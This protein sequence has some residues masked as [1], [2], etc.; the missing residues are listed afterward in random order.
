MAT[1][2]IGDV[3]GCYDSLRKLLDKLHFD[4]VSDV[5]WLTGDLVNRGPA[6]A[7]V[8]RFLKNMPRTQ[9]VLGNHDL[10]LLAVAQGH[11][12]R[13][14][15]DTFDDVLRAD[16]R[17]PLLDWLRYRPLAHFDEDRGILMVHAG[18]HP[19]WSL[20]QALDYAHDVQILLQDDRTYAQLLACMYGDQPAAPSGEM[21]TFER[22]RTIINAFTR[23]RYCDDAGHMDF[24]QVGPPGTQPIELRPWYEIAHIE[25]FRVVFGHWSMLGARALPNIISLDSGCVHGGQL[26]AVDLDQIPHGFVQIRCTGQSWGPSW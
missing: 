21:P 25:H 14:N 17:E 8:I 16:D 13:K 10:H 15:L 20:P 2:A 12:P 9:V 1:Y 5:L 3:Q 24:T 22:A 11:R 23:I 18:F 19:R 4:P 7:E 26:S 6:S